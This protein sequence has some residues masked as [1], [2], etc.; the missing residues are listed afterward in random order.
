VHNLR[1]GWPGH[2]AETPSRISPLPCRYSRGD[3]AELRAEVQAL[4]DWQATRDGFPNGYPPKGSK[5]VDDDSAADG[6]KS[7]HKDAE[8]V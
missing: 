2:S 5:M 4:R 7:A 3:V 8:A 6:T 1:D